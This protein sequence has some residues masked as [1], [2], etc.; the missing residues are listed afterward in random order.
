VKLRRGGVKEVASIGGDRLPKTIAA[1]CLGEKCVNWSGA[2]CAAYEDLLHTDGASGDIDSPP[3]R[4]EASYALYGLVCR[5]RDNEA[6]VAQRAEILKSDDA[7]TIP[8]IIALSG[9]YG[10]MPLFIQTPGQTLSVETVASSSTR[11]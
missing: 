1:Q 8:R 3:L 6:L 11:D 9:M 4:D 2:V 5:G 7:T 10:D